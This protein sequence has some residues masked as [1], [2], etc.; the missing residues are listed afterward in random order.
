MAKAELTYGNITFVNIGAGFCTVQKITIDTDNAGNLKNDS[1]R[2]RVWRTKFYN[3]GAVHNGQGPIAIT[4][5]DSVNFPSDGM[6]TPKG[7]A[8]ISKVSTADPDGHINFNSRSH[9]EANHTITMTARHVNGRGRTWKLVILVQH[10]DGRVGV[11]DPDV[12][13]EN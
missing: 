10:D 11:I 7:F 3:D 13:N 2:V 8:L 4:I 5:G 9:N 6:I 1:G 12:E